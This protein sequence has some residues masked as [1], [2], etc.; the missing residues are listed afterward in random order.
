[1]SEACD[2]N[3][4]QCLQ[5]C[6]DR[7][8][9]PVDF[10]EKL[11]DLSRVKRVIGI[12]SGKGGVG[13]SMVTALL[14][15]AMNRKGY[16]TAIMDADITGSS[17]PKMLGITERARSNED[18]LFPVRSQ[19]GIQVM[20][21]NVLLSQDT[22]PVI[23]RGPLIAGVVKQFWTDVIW[24]DVD[25]LFIDMPPGTGDVP[26]TVFQSIAVDG[27]VVVTSPQ[28]LVAMIVEKAVRMAG[29]MHIPIVGLVENMAYFRCPDNG[30]EYKIFGE[31]HIQDV[32]ETHGLEVLGRLP[33]DP[34]LARASD[35]GQIEYLEG[36]YLDLL[37]DR[38]EKM[39]KKD[40]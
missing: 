3:C 19:T 18:G 34:S 8:Q 24:R 21:M 27:I 13:K 39:E 15:V 38:I 16:R 11:H 36:G 7:T 23:W 10:S 28:E 12:V 25:Y 4:S 29:M 2:Q 6:E 31:S 26:L 35:S 30:R 17:I 33:V 37:A 40:D 22:D 5:E 14:A 20:S 9:A 32:A 1:M